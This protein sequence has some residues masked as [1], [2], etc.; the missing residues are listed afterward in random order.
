VAP[1]DTATMA[2]APAL[3]LAV[4]VMACVVPARRAMRVDPVSALRYE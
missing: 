3:L 2:A 1:T 4:A